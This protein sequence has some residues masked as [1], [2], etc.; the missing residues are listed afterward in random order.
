MFLRDVPASHI[1]CVD[2]WDRALEACEATG[3]PGRRLKIEQLPPSALPDATFDTVFAYSVFSHLS[4]RAHLA[5]RDEL[6]RATKG[7]AL[8]FITTQARWFLDTC[9]EFRE[10]PE[11]QTSGW[12]EAL[13]RA[14]VDYD[15]CVAGLD[16][17]EIHYWTAPERTVLGPD[18]GQTI[19]PRAYFEKEWDTDFEF[20]EF[21]EDRDSFEQAIAVLRRR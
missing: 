12:H 11:R 8:L 20:L 3:V 10:H 14:F 13:A 4:H 5:W 7:S 18:Y 15:A 2:S 16:R 17:G 19:V 21:I 6:A 1:W 9:R